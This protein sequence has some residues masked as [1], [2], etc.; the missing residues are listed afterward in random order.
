MPTARAARTATGSPDA[1][2]TV[3]SASSTTV[4]RMP[5]C[6]QRLRYGSAALATATVAATRATGNVA[7][8]PAGSPAGAARR[9]SRAAGPGP[10]RPATRR[11]PRAGVADDRPAL[12]HQGQHHHGDDQADRPDPPHRGH[13]PSDAV[14][15]RREGA[16]HRPLA[17]GIDPGGEP[18]Q[19]DDEQGQP[20]PEPVAPPPSGPT[21]ADRGEEEGPPRPRR[22]P[23]AAFRASRWCVPRRSEHL[24]ALPVRPALSI[25][26]PSRPEIRWA[27]AAVRRS[28]KGARAVPG[29]T[30]APGRRRTPRWSP[31]TGCVTNLGRGPD[32]APLADGRAPDGTRSRFDRTRRAQPA[33]EPWKVAS[34]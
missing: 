22:P 15:W 23:A 5:I 28:P 33:A 26:P 14:G 6:S 4:I 12:R 30:D 25:R 7:S 24:G 17:R 31:R 3:A 16:D 29:A 2:T 20:D 18:A 27:D 34:P 8:N 9:T 32:R 19:H 13:E 10:R 21:V 11:R 1:E